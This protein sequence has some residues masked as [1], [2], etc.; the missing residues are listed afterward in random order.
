M[1]IANFTQEFS[2]NCVQRAAEMKLQKKKNK[3][4]TPIIFYYISK[5]QG[6]ISDKR[7]PKFGNGIKI[8]F[9]IIERAEA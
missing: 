7:Y 2:Q 1:L 3:K 8:K 4:K 9:R 5:L 6:L